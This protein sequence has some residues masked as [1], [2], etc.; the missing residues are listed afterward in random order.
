MGM[1][2]T[3]NHAGNQTKNETFMIMNFHRNYCK[4]VF[5]HGKQGGGEKET[6]QFMAQCSDE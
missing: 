3:L 1:E 5:G 6:I 4:Q 2:N